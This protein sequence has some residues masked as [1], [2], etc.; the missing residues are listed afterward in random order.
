M[1][2]DF[3]N[4]WWWNELTQ[5]NK[6]PYIPDVEDYEPTEKE[7]DAIAYCLVEG[8][9]A[10]QNGIKKGYANDAKYEEGYQEKFQDAAVQRLRNGEW[11]DRAQDLGFSSSS[12]LADAIEAGKVTPYGEDGYMR[13]K[14]N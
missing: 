10:Y 5:P 9:K 6:K 1:S 13:F 3:W 14:K 2:S 8:E 7:K 4:G 11:T 12:E